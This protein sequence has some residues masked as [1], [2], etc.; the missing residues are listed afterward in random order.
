MSKIPVFVSCP[1]QLNE[2]QEKINKVIDE[3]LEELGL[4]RRAVGRTDYP[5]ENP[6]KEVCALAKHCAG[7]II[8]GF[9]QAFISE[10]TKKRNMK[11]ESK[12]TDRPLPSDWNNLE[13]GI[14]YALDLPLLVMKEEK[15]VGGIFDYGASKYF[16]NSMSADYAALKPILLKW[17]NQ[18]YRKYYD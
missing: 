18:V 11:E 17:S 15:I 6:L 12:I 4:E 10:G 7:G 8:L 5:V 14:L 1:T 13:A 9:E 16:V 3:I 2:E